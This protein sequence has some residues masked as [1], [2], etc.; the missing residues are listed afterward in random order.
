MLAIRQ[1]T[2]RGAKRKLWLAVAV[3]LLVLG[4]VTSTVFL[5]SSPYRALDPEVAKAM[6]DLEPGL[7]PLQRTALRT[8]PW[9]EPA[10]PRLFR[11]QPPAPGQIPVYHRF[12]HLGDRA[13][14]AVPHLLRMLASRD[15]MTRAG[16]FT[17]LQAL[18]VDPAKVAAELGSPRVPRDEVV[19]RVTW[20]LVAGAAYAPPGSQE[21]SWQLL[22]ALGPNATNAL[23]DLVGNLTE[24]RHV[25]QTL[26]VLAGMGTNAAAGLPAILGL[27]NDPTGYYLQQA[28]AAKAIGS[29]G[30]ATEPVM[31]ALRATLTN[32]PSVVRVRAAGALRRLG[33]PD[34]EVLSIL[35]PAATHKLA[36][37]R[38][39]ALEELAD[40]GAS[41]GMAQ[42]ATPGAAVP[43]T[44]PTR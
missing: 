12:S 40:I 14:P 42:E 19:R 37:V 33:A 21:W 16:A 31:T 20:E 35:D 24:K 6:A 30:M 11:R 36:T 43:A 1:V 27:L 22:T 28:E 8:C 10:F 41:R 39:A 3:G 34:Q 13:K 5:L 32:A 25:G 4:I 23:P 38:A 7:S 44:R 17:A 2:D 9:L 18:R 29:I 26:G 15:P